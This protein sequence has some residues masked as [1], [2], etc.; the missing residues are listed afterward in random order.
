MAHHLRNV[1]VPAV[2]MV[3]RSHAWRIRETKRRLEEELE[4]LHDL[5]RVPVIP[6]LG[7]RFPWPWRKSSG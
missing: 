1:S 2:R 5:K 6:R 4:K 7:N 3:D